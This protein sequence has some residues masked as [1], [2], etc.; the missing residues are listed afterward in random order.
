M[1]GVLEGLSC[2]HAQLRYSSM[3]ERLS[4]C[5]EYVEIDFHK[6]AGRLG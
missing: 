4:G 1:P 2:R 3:Y 6:S 5:L